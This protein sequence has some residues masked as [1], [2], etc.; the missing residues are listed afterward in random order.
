MFEPLG[1]SASKRA[2][3][4]GLGSSP[5]RAPATRPGRMIRSLVFG[6]RETAAWIGAHMER[7][8]TNRAFTVHVL[9]HQTPGGGVLN[10][11]LAKRRR[12]PRPR[13]IAWC[14][15]ALLVLVACAKPPDT[16]PKKSWFTCQAPLTRRVD[17]FSASMRA[18]MARM[19]E[20]MSVAPGGDPDR[21]FAA[22]MLPHHQGAVEMAL[23]ELRFGREE[24]L[25]RLAAGIIVEQRSEIALLQQILGRLNAPSPDAPLAP[26]PSELASEQGARK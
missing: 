24:Q 22:M 15:P 6:R 8:G 10:A 9:A 13:P 26:L 21:D 1:S 7:H 4:T 20:R 11:P 12:T 5:R 17:S 23:A 16:A 14:A 3:R 2:A 25:R 18:A 19:D